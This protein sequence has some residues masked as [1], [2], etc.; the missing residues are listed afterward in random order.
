[1]KRLIPLV[2]TLL[3][4]LQACSL[5][6]GQTAAPLTPEPRL[7]EP[8]VL[9]PTATVP[10]TPEPTPTATPAP[11]SLVPNGFIASPDFSSLLFYSL[12]GA[13]I[14]SLQVNDLGYI[15]PYSFHVAGVMAGGIPPL[16]YFRYGSP[17]VIQNIGGNETVLVTEDDYYQ[18]TGGR[19][20]PYFA[21]STATLNET[22]IVTRL[23][24]GAPDTIR[25]AEPVLEGAADNSLALKPLA[26]DV[27]G[28]LPTI[29]WYTGCWY[30][31]GGDIV[32]PPCNRL[33]SL[34]LETGASREVLGDDL[35]PSS[36]SPDHTWVAYSQ[37]GEGMP[38]SI[39]NL[40]TGDDFSFPAWL[41]NDR[42]SGEAAFSPDNAYVAWMEGSGYWLMEGTPTFHSMV[43]VGT[44]DGL[45]FGEY[46]SEYFDTAA[47]FAVRTAAP[48][49]WLDGDSVLIQVR[50]LEAQEAALV[51]LDLPDTPV[52]LASGNFAGLTYP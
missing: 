10:P 42:G 33:I 47:G 41:E 40:V 11:V 44:T 52:F 2:L 39:R 4:V 46:P 38:L 30:G 20:S 9:V 49:A 24:V 16:L 45:L 28:G 1:M 50:G 36:L 7:T 26:L 22:G 51:R 21:Y 32:F 29:L 34:D 18:M 23:Y 35:N 37:I 12:E 43:R 17:Q 48:V 13:V 15:T 3:C 31:I 8:S 27:E 14:G 5:Q 6:S 25:D 19:G